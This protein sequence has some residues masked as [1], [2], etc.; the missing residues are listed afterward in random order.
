MSFFGSSGHVVEVRPA[1]CSP[2]GRQSLG[3]YIIQA[4]CHLARLILEVSLTVR[5]GLYLILLKLATFV[6]LLSAAARSWS[7]GYD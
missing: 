7:L 5:V 6:L 4:C 2:G 1:D 3:C